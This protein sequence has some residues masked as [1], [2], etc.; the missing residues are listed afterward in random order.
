MLSSV[1]KI[2]FNDIDNT[3]CLYYSNFIHFC[4]KTF[5]NLFD[6][7][8]IFSYTNLIKIKKIGNT[9]ILIHYNIYTCFPNLN[10]TKKHIK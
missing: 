4:H 7:K 10:P 8:W 1:Q 5:E 3:G 9:S 6:E 2:R